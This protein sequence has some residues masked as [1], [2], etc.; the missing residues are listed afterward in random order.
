MTHF[1]TAD[2]DPE[3]TSAQLERFAPF[4]AAKWRVPSALV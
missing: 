1:A 2:E 3:F 4:A